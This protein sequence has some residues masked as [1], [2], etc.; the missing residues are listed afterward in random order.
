M[1]K[2][3]LVYLL[4]F[5]LSLIIIR[6]LSQINQLN[7]LL[8]IKTEAAAIDGGQ[9]IIENFSNNKSQEKLFLKNKPSAETIFILGSSELMESSDA[10]PYNFISSHFA[11]QLHGVGHAGNQCFSIYSQ[12]MANEQ[13]LK[14]ASIV[15]ILSPGWFESKASGGTTSQ[16]FLEF[17]S[18][19]FLNRIL[20]DPN[21]TVFHNYEY[22]RVAQLYDEFNSPNLELKLMNF[23]YRVSRS[24][25]HC[26][27][28]SPLIFLDQLLL[29]SK[30]QII[31]SEYVS[32]EPVIHQSIVPENVKIRWDSLYTS[33]KE[34]V[35]KKVTNNPLGIA[36]DY[37]TEYIHGKMGHIDAV[38][39]VFNKELSDCNMLI[40]L[41]KEKKVNAS[42]I[43]SPLNPFY[44]KNLAEILPTMK[45]VEDRLRQANFPY[46]N[47]LTTDTTRY[48][49]AILH[50][51]MHMSDY[52]WYQVNHFIVNNYHLA[53]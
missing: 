1:K 49:K 45:L 15:I 22:K 25:L 18:E 36:D 10:L 7:G 23:R 21:Q 30:K 17:N 47:L 3:A 11:T 24:A 39:S 48:E 5:F 19:N 40:D 6:N 52:G 2:F 20:E 28:Y 35:L 13:K 33:S 26:L 16:L 9:R 46:L 29:K 32:N 27:V 38:G 50:D 42:F 31:P 12:L 37:Y 51:V 53:K 43:I 4:P 14:N 44:Y 41:L 8:F 34:E